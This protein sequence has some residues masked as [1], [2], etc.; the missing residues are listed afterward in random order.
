MFPYPINDTFNTV[1][2]A[3]ADSGAD[4]GSSTPRDG[5]SK[6]A[7]CEGIKPRQSTP[8]AGGNHL[9]LMHQKH[10]YEGE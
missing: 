1:D 9:S 10:G 7:T 4:A 8:M 5:S 2:R 6:V 3:A